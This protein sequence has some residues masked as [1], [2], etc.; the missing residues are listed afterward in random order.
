[1]VN[2]LIKGLLAISVTS[3]LVACGGD[4]GC[5]PDS[6]TI[7]RDNGAEP[8]TLDPHRAQGVP[9][10]N[11]LR[12]M[13]EGLFTEGAGGEITWG[14]AENAQINDR[15]AVF[16]LRKNALWSNGDPVTAHDFVYSFRR[17]VDPKTNS[18]YA[19]ILSPIVN[20]DD[21][22]KKKKPVESLGVKALDKH[23]LEIRLNVPT[24]Y[25]RG[26]LTHSI[27]YPVHEASVKKHGARF[28]RPENS[29]SN[30]PYVLAERSPDVHIKLKKNDNYH[31]ADSV[32]VENIYYL[33]IKDRN[34]AE[35]L[36]RTGKI[37]F[38]DSLPPGK[39]LCERARK[40]YGSQLHEAA[41]LGTYYY[42]F[43]MTK[44]KFQ[45]KK[46]RH[47][48][49]LAIDRSHIVNTI[50]GCGEVEAYSWVAKGAYR[51]KS[52][53]MSYM[54]MTQKER[55][56]LA[57]KLYAEAGYS[58]ANPLKM[59]LLYN[60]SDGHRKIAVAVTGMW[61]KV[62]GVETTLENKEWK[63][64][65]KARKDKNTVEVA[66]AGWIADYNDPHTF[67]EIFVS[68]HGQNDAHYANPAYD[69]QLAKANRELNVK[70]RMQMIAEA[71]RILLEDMPII[72]I[73]FYSSK[74]VINPALKGYKDNIM[75]HHPSRYMW[76]MRQPKK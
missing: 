47:A 55:E 45:N 42:T 9:A 28:V 3:L 21:I 43:N 22:I 62:L 57:R 11:V 16:N 12:D 64:F 48:L 38:L 2:S 27:T 53:E 8:A 54:K 7:C 40:R 36:Y 46:L 76:L 49:A 20:A 15:V 60:S 31:A 72:P 61:K 69:A 4:E 73:Y 5:V 51:Y 58:A 75:D 71:E 17:A 10:S 44:P 63:T 66:R 39:P 32:Q 13:Y 56:T 41:I 52:P 68:D 1:M 14:M 24:S 65:L 34:T 35:K 70:K 23:T 74:N 18:D 26:M 50:T 30:G 25:L 37:D 6:N 19:K 67:T 59:D 33:A 29:V